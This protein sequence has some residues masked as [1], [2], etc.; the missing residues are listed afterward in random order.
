MII[1]IGRQL[2][3][4]GREIGKKLAETMNI[5][6]YDKEILDLTAK[7]S[8][9]NHELFDRMDERVQKRFL[10][11][12]RGMYFPVWGDNNHMTGYGGLSDEMLFQLQ[13]DVIRKT[14]D[15]QSCVF[16][17]RCADYILRDRKDC[18][19]VFICANEENRIKR[20]IDNSEQKAVSEEK[21]RDLMAQVDKRRATYYG[22]YTNKTW[23][24]A[25]SY[26][27]CLNSSVTGVNGAVSFIKEIAEKVCG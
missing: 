20:I 19:N 26:H 6:Y 8:G 3:S 24:V 23:G 2:G 14:A 15:K 18:L 17:G 11:G 16:I 10:T 12:L 13:S 22:F 9:F 5:A 27:I 1:T 7:E 4:G 21:A 25:S